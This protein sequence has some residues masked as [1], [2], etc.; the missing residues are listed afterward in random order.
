MRFW[1]W[2]EIKAKIQQDTDIEDENFI[3]SDELLALAN[4]AID[5][6][7]AEIHSLYEDY[8]LARSVVTVNAGD[9]YLS[10]PTNIYAN[11]LREIIFKNGSTVYTIDRLKD[12]K[13]FKEKAFADANQSTNKPH[14]FIINDTPGQ[15]QI[16]LVPKAPDTGTITIWYLRNANRLIAN[17][18]ICDIP[19][20]IN[21]I[22]AHMKMKIYAK[23]GHPDY[24]QSLERLETER[25]RMVEV[26]SNMV[27]DSENE[28]E[29][30]TT[31]YNDMN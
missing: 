1:S 31:F 3:R 12:W 16:M 26:L 17:A 27:P 23:E 21:F 22:F 5:E 19:E 13:K 14:Y 4:E 9:E 7:E 30:D 6:A 25:K 15:P 24:A 18:D 11:K 8:F 20:F 28:L 29:Q 10:M 2:Q